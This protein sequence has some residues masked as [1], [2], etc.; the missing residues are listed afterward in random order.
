M[1]VHH[2]AVDGVS[3]RI[4]L[5]DLQKAYEQQRR[6]E[7]VKLGAK[8]SS[9]Q[10]WAK[11]LAE[12]AKREGGGEREREYW[13]T[14][15]GEWRKLERD[16]EGA[17]TAETAEQVTVEL[18]KEKTR[19]LLEQVPGVY[20]TQIGEVLM[21]ALVRSVRRWTGEGRLWVEME[22]HGREPILEEMDV[23]RTVGWFTTMYPMWRD[24]A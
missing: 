8:T 3:W 12:Y 22:G 13:E 24:P 10:Q 17:N 5:E 9:Y 15:R 4:V 19:E 6:G 21:A 1:V 11:G 7:R 18:E 2:L 16:R 14:E 23:T 20:R